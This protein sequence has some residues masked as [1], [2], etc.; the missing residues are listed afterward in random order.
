MYLLEISLN[1]VGMISCGIFWNGMNV[2]QVLRWSLYTLRM[3]G[4]LYA[5]L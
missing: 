2:W 5:A 1:R 4:R 3:D